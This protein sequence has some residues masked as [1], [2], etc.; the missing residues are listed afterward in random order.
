LLQHAVREEKWHNENP[1]ASPRASPGTSRTVE[2]PLQLIYIELAHAQHMIDRSTA[3][4]RD[5]ADVPTDHSPRS[6]ALA[7]PYARVAIGPAYDLT[8]DFHFEPRPERCDHDIRPY[9]PDAKL[10]GL[11][12]TEAHQAGAMG[13]EILRLGAELTVGTREEKLVGDE[14]VEGIYVSIELR[15]P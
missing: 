7:G 13:V 4:Y 6:P 11:V 10:L 2:R 8:S 5:L 1:R 14:E 3:L 12:D 9:A 15:R